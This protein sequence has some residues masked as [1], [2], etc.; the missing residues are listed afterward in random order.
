MFTVKAAAFKNLSTKP[1]VSTVRVDSRRI[2]PL[3]VT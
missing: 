3:R 2:D 1:E